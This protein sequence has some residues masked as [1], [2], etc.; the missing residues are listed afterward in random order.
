MIPTGDFSDQDNNQRKSFMARP[1]L[2]ILVLILF[3][4]QG[5]YHYP[6]QAPAA[7]PSTEYKK[8]TAHSLFWGLAQ[9]NVSAENCQPTPGLAEV[10]VTTNLGFAL[11]TVVTLGI[12]CP[13]TVEW[14]CAKP[15]QD[16]GEL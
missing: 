13:M 6:V 14:R 4:Q 11:A 8:Q 1:R 3:L 9:K 12:W 16:N 10:R 7:D 2:S 15:C 5:C